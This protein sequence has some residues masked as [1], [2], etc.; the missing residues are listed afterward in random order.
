MKYVVGLV[1]VLIHFIG[2]SQNPQ[3]YPTPDKGCLA[4]HQGIEPIREHD[5]KMM[6]AIYREG[7]KVSDPNGC[8]VCH[9]GNPVEEKDKIWL[10]GI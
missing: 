1:I 8:V 3:Q 9:I 2:F 6:R 10:I 5:S 4:C 7:R